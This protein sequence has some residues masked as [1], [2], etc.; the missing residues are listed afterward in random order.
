MENNRLLPDTLPSDIELLGDGHSFQD[1][2][3]AMLTEVKG[4]SSFEPSDLLF[5]ARHMQAYRARKGIT[6]FR[7][8]DQNC[9]LCVLVT[10]HISVYK[11]D[12]GRE[13]KL[14]GTITPGKI[15]GEISIIDNLPHSATLVAESD[16]IFL[17]MN[18]ES[19]RQC[20][21]HEP[22][23]GVRLLGLIARLLCAR[24]RSASGQLA[25]FIHI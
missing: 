3:A 15:F 8:G 6:I 7:E 11:E 24:L 19:F 22:V 2:I 14:L 13:T 17:L 18:Q 25:E 4:F 20:T 10:G 21:E 23:L 12:Q 5:L 16:A 9:Y 1:T